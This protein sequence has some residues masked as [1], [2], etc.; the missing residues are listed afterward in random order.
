[1][2]ESKNLGSLISVMIPHLERWF[3]IT[4]EGI[5]YMNH[6]KKSNSTFREYLIYPKDMEIKIF[7][8]DLSLMMG[9]KNLSLIFNNKTVFLDVLYSILKGYHKSGTTKVNRFGSFC[10]IIPNSNVHFYVNGYGRNYFDDMYTELLK[11]KREV[12]INDWFFSP[13]IHLK[14]PCE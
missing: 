8:M 13:K 6:N 10:E 1:M 7:G 14:R 12:F 4:Q 11:A 5:G 3:V 9:A 2:S